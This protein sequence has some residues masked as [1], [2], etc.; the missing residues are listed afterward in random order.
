MAIRDKNKGGKVKHHLEDKHIYKKEFGQDDNDGQDAMTWEN[1]QKDWYNSERRFI[2]ATDSK[3]LRK[4]W[5]QLIMQ[6]KRPRN[7]NIR[8]PP[9]QEK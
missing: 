8:G 6:D 5:I 4:K 7:N 2:F 9:T 3:I 1:R